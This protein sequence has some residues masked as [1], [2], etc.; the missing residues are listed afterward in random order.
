MGAK[1]RPADVT[2]RRERD[3]AK[4][5]PGRTWLRSADGNA[6]EISD[7][8]GAE[9]FAADFVMRCRLLLDERDFVSGGSQSKSQHRA[10]RAT[11]DD[12]MI[13]EASH[14][15]ARCLIR[16]TQSRAGVKLWMV[17]SD[18][19]NPASAHILRQ[20]SGMKARAMETGPSC[21]TKGC[22]FA[23]FAKL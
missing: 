16:P 13:D 3:E 19:F 8:F 11:T 9:E 22:R 23:S 1:F 5:I 20:S 12:E 6:L 14:Q 4:R 7:G 15:W 2:I 10:S 21:C 18:L 17:I